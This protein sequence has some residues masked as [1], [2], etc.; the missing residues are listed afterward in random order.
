MQLPERR[1]VFEK[2]VGEIVLIIQYI[3][4]ARTATYVSTT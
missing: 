1:D 3:I 2:Y 4:W